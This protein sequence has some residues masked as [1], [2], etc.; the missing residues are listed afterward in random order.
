MLARLQSRNRVT[1]SGPYCRS[2]SKV[3]G[4]RHAG[5]HPAQARRLAARAQPSLSPVQRGAAAA[6]I[7]AAQAA[8]DGR[9]ETPAH[10]AAPGG[11]CL[12]DGLRR[13]RVRLVARHGAPRHVFVDNGS[14]FTGRLT[15]MWAYP[16]RRRAGLQQAGQADRQQLRRDL[17]RLATR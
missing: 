1:V 16:P 14:E 6:A 12:D 11:R 4:D 17:Q 8:Q 9:P 15:D 13:R 3:C 7:E 5:A 10:R 2:P